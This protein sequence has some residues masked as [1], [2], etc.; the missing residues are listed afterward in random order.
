M[1]SNMVMDS[2]KRWSISGDASVIDTIMGMSARHGDKSLSICAAAA[3]WMSLTTDARRAILMQYESARAR[4]RFG[5]TVLEEFKRLQ[6]QEAEAASRGE[7]LERRAAEELA[8]LRALE[9]IPESGPKR[10]NRRPA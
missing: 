7:G 9:P 6:E 2:K 4:S 5:G 10:S 3:F 8:R 1:V